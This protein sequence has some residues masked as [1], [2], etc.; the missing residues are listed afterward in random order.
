MIQIVIYLIVFRWLKLHRMFKLFNKRKIIQS[1][2][3]QHLQFLIWQHMKPLNIWVQRSGPMCPVLIIAWEQTCS[4]WMLGGKINKSKEIMSALAGQEDGLMD[5]DKMLEICMESE[6]DL[7]NLCYKFN[8][9]H[10]TVTFTIWLIMYFWA[11]DVGVA[12]FQFER[13]QKDVRKKYV[14]TDSSW[15]LG[16]KDWFLWRMW[17]ING[18]D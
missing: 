18:T 4:M 11:R 1:I 16:I 7:F 15:H 13:N 2:Q 9:R 6:W 5:S 12:P 17:R 14:C 8:Q 3:F 10:V